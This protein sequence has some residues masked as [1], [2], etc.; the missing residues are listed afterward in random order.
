MGLITV[1]DLLS[2]VEMSQDILIEDINGVEL[3]E[4]ENATAPAR[5]NDLYI[6]EVWVSSR[7]HE[8]VIDVDFDTNEEDFDEE[9]DWND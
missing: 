1:G 5:L 8:L 6:L 2:V 3:Y 7:T 4:G 9:E